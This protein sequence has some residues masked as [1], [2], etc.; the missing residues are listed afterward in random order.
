MTWRTDEVA[1]KTSPTTLFCEPW[2]RWPAV[3]GRDMRRRHAEDFVRCRIGDQVAMLSSRPDEGMDGGIC[4]DSTDELEE[5]MERVGEV[6][7]RLPRIEL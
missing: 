7:Q 4:E 6:V 5:R 1:E 3:L 2:R